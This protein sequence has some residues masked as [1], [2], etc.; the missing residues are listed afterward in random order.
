MGK[1]VTLTGVEQFFDDD[2]IIVS[3]TNLKGHLTYTNKIFLDI[4]GYHENE[5]IGKPHNVI[6]HPDMPRSVF[7]TL[8]DT[9]QKGD[10]VFAYV[11]NRCKNG[12]HYWVYAHV[13]PS[14]NN[15]GQIV[16]YHSNRRVPDRK[17]LTDNIIPLYQQLKTEED[18]HTSAKDGL[19]AG[20]QMLQNILTEAN[21]AYD[22]FIATIGQGLRRGYR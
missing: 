16:G 22:E 8:W 5:V 1:Q 11:V 12:D 13:T 6:R 14:R 20:T 9:V 17:I 4:S 18:Q 2:D 10:E 7:K 21:V 19:K 3:K 15:D